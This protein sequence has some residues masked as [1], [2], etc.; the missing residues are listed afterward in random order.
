MSLTC[1]PPSLT[2]WYLSMD[3][4]T[5]WKLCNPALYS[6]SDLGVLCTLLSGNKTLVLTVDPEMVCIP[7]PLP[8]ICALRAPR[9]HN[10]KQLSSHDPLWKSKRHHVIGHKT[11]LGMFRK[12]EIILNI[13][14]DHHSK[15]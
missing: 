4:I 7:A 12:T 13:F 14:S 5:L 1:I 2:I 8:L 9:E 11:N 15:K 3:K 10:P 6:T